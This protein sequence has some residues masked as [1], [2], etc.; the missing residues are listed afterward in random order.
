M[1]KAI[2]GAALLLCG[3]ASMAQDTQSVEV[4]SFDR[5]DVRNGVAVQVE[6]G[7]EPGIVL[8]GDADDFDKIEIDVRDGELVISR[9]TRWF[10]SNPG[11]DVIIRVSGRQADEIQVRRGASARV[12]GL[13]VERL[14]LSISTGAEA[15]MSGSCGELDL[16]VSTGAAINAQ[17]LVCQRVDVSASTGASA[18]VHATGYAQASAGTGAAVWVFGD[19]DDRELRA[20]M[21]GSARLAAFEG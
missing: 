4:S 2:T 17:N 19:P 20:S 3:S 6:F 11:L 16:N 1:L 7:G 13:D 21:G 12:T 9:Q 14:E 8:E 10:G 5:M 15:A 18:R